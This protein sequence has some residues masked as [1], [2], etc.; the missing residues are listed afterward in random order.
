MRRVLIAAALTLSIAG[1]AVARVESDFAGSK[2]Q[3]APNVDAQVLWLA[4][5]GGPTILAPGRI[6]TDQDTVD[7]T[8][9]VD[10]VGEVTL[11]A[12]GIPIP[13]SSSR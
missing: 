2:G 3:V 11:T 1:T 13:G 12:N 4:Q 5:A 6:D 10:G 7:F 8:G 9:K